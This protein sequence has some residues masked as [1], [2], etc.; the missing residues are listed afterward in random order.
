MKYLKPIGIVMAILL[1]L[2]VVIYYSSDFF[3]RSYVKQK[4][5]E[6]SEEK[7]EVDFDRF[8]ISLFQ[9]GIIFEGFSLNP[10][11]EVFS[12]LTDIPYYKISIPKIS[13]TRLNYL[14]RKKELQLGMIHLKSP[15][16]EFRLE[17]ELEEMY[18][19]G[20]TSALQLLEDEIKKS[21][22]NIGLE[23]IRIK[24]LKV[25]DA[26]LLFKNFISQRAIK[27]ENAY[28][29]VKDIQLLQTRSPET[30]L[31]AEGFTL[32]LENF[33]ILLADS[34]HTIKAQEVH[35][36][37]LEQFI[38]AKK[39]DI[40][41][42]LN[43]FSTNY[44]QVSLEDLKLTDAD[45][46][47][48]FYTSEVEVGELKLFKPEFDLYTRVNESKSEKGIFDL[49][50]L[51][52]GILS[53]ISIQNLN[54]EEGKFTQRDVNDLKN[55]RIKA[56]QINFEMQEVYV[57]PN[58]IKKKDQ[59][60][61]A[62][63]ASLELKKV[64]VALGDKIHLIKGELVTLSSFT[65]D[66]MIKGATIA[67]IEDLQINNEVTLIEIKVPQLG[68]SDANLR[69]IYNQ[70]IIDIKDVFLDRPE[71]VLRDVMG[72]LDGESKPFD[73]QGLTEDFLK[74]I[75]IQRFEVNQGSLVID[76]NIR[77][78]QDSLSFGNISFVLEKFALD[79]FIDKGDRKG[80][81]LAEELQIELTDYALKLAD[82][83][84]VF[85]ADR[86]F[87]DTKTSRVQIDGFS[88]S[89][90]SPDQIQTS[91]DRY[92]KN[93]ILDIYVPQFLA[94][95]VD[96][97]EAIFNDK[98]KI[99]QIRV[100]SP[101]I[102]VYSYRTKDDDGEDKVEK[103]EILDL[104]GNYFSE[105]SVDSLILIKGSLN[106]EN[107]VR[108]RMRTFAEDNVS[109]AVKNFH[110]DKNTKPEDFRL[111]YSEEVDLKLNNYVFS[112]ADGRYN[113]IADRINFNTSREEIVTSNVRLTPSKSSEFKTQVSAIIPTLS[114]TGVDLEAFL[115]DNSLSLNKVKFSG[116]SVNILVNRDVNSSNV[117]DNEKGRERTLPKTINIINIDTVSAENANFSLSF[118]EEGSRRELVN[119]G[120]N[121]SV[122][123]FL[124]DSTILAKGDI[125]GF[126]GG[127]A[128]DVDEFWLTLSDSIHRVT[129]SKVEL[130]TRYE[131]VLLNNL[132]VIPNTL[133]GKPGSPVFSGHIPT[134]LIKTSALADI[135][136]K[137]DLWISELRLFRPDIEIFLDDV[138]LADQEKEF[139]E[140]VESVLETIRID[141]FEIV[142]GNLAFFNKD[143]SKD[144]R[145]FNNLNITLD[146]M[147]LN[148]N[149][150]ENFDKSDILKK[151]FEVSIPNYKIYTK[152]CLNVVNIGLASV[153]ND[154]ISLQNVTM[155]PRIGRFAYAREIGKEADIAE[156]FIPE[157]LV[158][159][160]NLEM[161]IDNQELHSVL[162][163]VEDL[164]AVIYRDK[165][166]P[167]PKD[168]Y[169][170]MPQELMKQVGFIVKLDTLV[171]K[172]GT[173]K[174]VEF[175]KNGLVPGKISFEE[176]YATIFPFHLGKD[177]ENYQVDQG[178][179]L[180][181]A[182]LNGEAPLN[183]QGEMSFSAPYPMTLNVQIGEF[184]LR[185]INSILIPNAFARIREGTVKSGNWNFTA[186]NKEA[187]GSM[188]FLYNDLK[189]DLLDER[190]LEKGVGRKKILTFV[191]NVFAV[192]SNNPRKFPRNT[193][194]GSIYEPRNTEKFIFNY[195]W[196]T[197]ISGLKGSVGLGQSKPPKKLPVLKRKEDD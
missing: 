62:K 77:V 184:D 58:E 148:L 186:D 128:L 83:L 156:I 132:R 52:K 138:D 16:I 73:L 135:Q 33:E 107:Y 125:S 110:I 158:H 104:L 47:K 46:N 141:E 10:V 121:L 187:I 78:R 169:K 119:T 31:N 144:P 4:V 50:E 188:L 53:A 149:D 43:R 40:N 1:T 63:D 189:L 127:L 163:E 56:D 168:V 9:R 109:I 55:H 19:E 17:D 26:D 111:L 60:F 123:D 124:L 129:F 14:F 81:F 164:D 142:D 18:V 35:I 5:S 101:K 98:L 42:D 45:I 75:Y 82:N 103:E 116:S 162:L 3:L 39:V 108:D 72:D 175:P 191:L 196:T 140:E 130:D 2:Q 34:V 37:S 74:A 38:K 165:R 95:G 70:G 7:Y 91:L 134:A 84:H 21:F 90:F 178:T 115:F 44:F 79:N 49:Y 22:G 153:K 112:I 51:V 92:D 150:L 170:Y 114:F 96:I 54:I 80:F 143:T 106:Y 8:Y 185:S 13:L 57:G 94:T 15:S 27:M 155:K 192:R 76:N 93:T 122:Y 66:I 41:P 20:E 176:L 137:K 24:N 195:W 59:F 36:S 97:S 29:H 167:A 177:P 139:K 86:L 71:I 174:Y 172:N 147:Y 133:S 100:P 102:N 120:I 64:E 160:P 87:L 145:H 193:V 173:I 131:G 151:D 32:D 197:T 171:L 161:L 68:I 48:V 28:I 67:P 152:D 157:I 190:T 159:H 89:P 23:E 179:L 194:R 136:M 154:L 180:A 25:D 99:D 11:D 65:D 166:F 6:S 30:P 126:F 85:K 61:Y 88:I 181:S 117:S 69:K 146:K 12:D 183:L 182:K 113:I 105:V 118:Q